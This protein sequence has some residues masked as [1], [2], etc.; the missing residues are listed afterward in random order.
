MT[1]FDY[2]R[3]HRGRKILKLTGLVLTLAGLA[4]IIDMP[5]RVPIPLTGIRALI[6]GVVLIIFGVICL[7]HGYKLP[8]NEAIEIIHQRGEGITALELIHAMR[9]DRMTANRII[10][11]LVRKGFLRST[12]DRSNTEPVFDAV[13]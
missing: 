10:E 4:T 13:K 8:L 9:V 6:V 11:A 3:F 5:W 1:P 12:V 2:H 7:Y